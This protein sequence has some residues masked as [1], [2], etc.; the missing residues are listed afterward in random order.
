[1]IWRV[2]K[3]KC[4]LADEPS[5]PT[6]RSAR[7]ALLLLAATFSNINGFSAS[8]APASA[9]NDPG[10]TDIAAVEYLAK[11]LLPSELRPKPLTL[12]TPS[13][14]G[15]TIRRTVPEVRLRFSVF[16]ERGRLVT[17]LSADDIRVLDDQSAVPRIRQFTRADDLPVQVG[18]LLDV[19][20][21]V[22]KTIAREKLAAT[23]FAERVLRQEADRAFLMAFGRD[24]QL[25]QDAT[26]DPATLK[27]AVL[28]IRQL[29]H[30]TNLYDSVFY[31]CLNQFS[32]S[33][34]GAAT[35]RI[36]LLLSD[37]EDTGSFHSMADAIALAQRREIQ[38]YA[39]SVHPGRKYAPGDATLRRLAEET[40]G[41]LYLAGSEKDFPA[42]F[43]T[44]ERQ[45]R[46]QYYVSFPPQRPT[47]G[48][49]DLRIE[50]T[51]NRNLRIHARQGYY[52]DAP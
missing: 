24:V 18:L 12:A 38:I 5:V 3:P 16:D 21:S 48:F 35:Q 9:S 36:L 30:T 4:G 32:K 19:S 43:A 11:N 22:Q 50:T 33:D 44:M 23:A 47:P 41:Q 39:L 13:L 8:P 25:S 40:G 46:T 7:N 1:M 26:S 14:P 51:S 27:Q 6:K 52:F 20:D 10:S 17:D 37:G 31:S 2:L 34:G 49:H 45:M 28:R 29:G 15:Y 42:I